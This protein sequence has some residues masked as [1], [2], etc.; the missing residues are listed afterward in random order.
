MNVLLFLRQM[1]EVF[2]KQYVT[3]TL[4]STLSNH[5]NE[6]HLSFENLWG[7][8]NYI[9]CVLWLTNFY[10]LVK[11]IRYKMKHFQ[12]PGKLFSTWKIYILKLNL[13]IFTCIKQ[14]VKVA[15]I[16]TCICLKISFLKNV[17][18]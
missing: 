8:Q 17:F 15:S 10:L 14:T 3:A 12:V 18:N 9:V 6:E 2:T 16:V 1:A 11:R 7:M 13:N 4:N 5:Q